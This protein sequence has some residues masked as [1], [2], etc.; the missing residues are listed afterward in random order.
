MNDFFLINFLSIM[1]I[2][3]TMISFNFNINWHA[4]WKDKIMGY[5]IFVDL[6]FT[7]YHWQGEVWY[8]VIVFTM[9]YLIYLG[10]LEKSAN[11][12]HKK[13]QPWSHFKGSTPP[14]RSRHLSLIIFFNNLKKLFRYYVIR[15]R[16]RKYVSNIV[17][18]YSV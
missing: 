11:L 7:G 3:K 15:F 17:L 13:Y 12:I 1:W 14:V 10:I 4:T 16:V 5:E 2:I 6:L 9:T 8:K 18:V